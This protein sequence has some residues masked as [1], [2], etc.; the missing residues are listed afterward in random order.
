MTALIRSTIQRTPS[1]RVCRFSLD[2]QKMIERLSW[3]VSDL[4]AREK[5]SSKQLRL[6]MPEVVLLSRIGVFTH[7]DLALALNQDLY[8][9][10]GQ[11][12][13][14]L[15]KLQNRHLGFSADSAG[16][17]FELLTTPCLQA[18][19]ISQIS[20]GLAAQGLTRMVH[21]VR[22]PRKEL[23]DLVYR[24]DMDLNKRDLSRNLGQV[25]TEA[26]LRFEMRIPSEFRRKLEEGIK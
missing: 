8:P 6:V 22:K 18:G 26:E 9:I 13:V 15:R 11:K 21:V 19:F 5:R 24:E 2:A 10:F 17:L 12:L 16:V 14:T 1:R 3:P 25:I 23:V 7:F 4:M 20:E